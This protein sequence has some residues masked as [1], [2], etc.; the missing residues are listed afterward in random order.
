MTN[1]RQTT[2]QQSLIPMNIKNSSIKQAMRANLEGSVALTKATKLAYF[3]T[4]LPQ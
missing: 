1:S 4:K 2:Q 3:T